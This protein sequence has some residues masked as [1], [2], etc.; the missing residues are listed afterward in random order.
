MKNVFHIAMILNIFSLNKIRDFV[1]NC[2][3][4]QSM[5]PMV[6]KAELVITFF[7][8]NQKHLKLATLFLMHC[9]N[10]AKFSIYNNLY[11]ITSNAYIPYK[12]SINRVSFHPLSEIN[13]HHNTTWRTVL[14]S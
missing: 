3:I 5:G 4:V 6:N 14:S 12:P 13:S 2:N 11:E 8:I 10:C 9:R 1:F 7:Y